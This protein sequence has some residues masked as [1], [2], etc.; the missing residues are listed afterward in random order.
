MKNSRIR[1]ILLALIVAALLIIPFFAA[2]APAT[3][4]FRKEIPA[5]SGQTLTLENLA[6]KVLVEGKKDGPVE[7]VA[8]IHAESDALLAE[9]PIDVAEKGDAIEVIARYPVEKHDAYHYA[10][11]DGGGSTSTTYL[12]HRVKV[13]SGVLSGGVELWADFLLRVPAGTGAS[14]R[15]EV[16]KIVATNVAGRLSVRSGSGD[17]RVDGG[18]GETTARTGSGDVSVKGRSGRVEARTGSGEVA[19]AGITGDVQVHT[20][21]GNAVV[22]DVKGNLDAQ[23]GSGN[24]T[25]RKVTG[26]QV[27]AKTGSGEITL[28]SVSGSLEAHTGSGE[29]EGEE[30]TITGAL[31]LDTGSGDIRLGGNFMGLSGA[32]VG[33]G[34]GDVSLTMTKTPGMKLD[35]GTSSGSI[36]I[37]VPGTKLKAEKRLELS[38]GNGAA[39]VKVRTSSGSIVIAGS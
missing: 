38:T 26:N 1:P 36:R 19:L 29:I 30:V 17:V 20:G 21:S 10:G 32:R 14:V 13:G 24:V 4:E 7:I 39:N 18:E 33:T 25:A 28:R 5:R 6:G 3:K 22:D 15:N 11:G 35:L 27:K 9:L 2:A 34:S 8:T 23:T 12:G 31:D 37:D 16:G